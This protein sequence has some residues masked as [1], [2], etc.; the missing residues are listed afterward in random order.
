LFLSILL[1]YRSY[2]TKIQL[3]VLLRV[4]FLY[5][6]LHPTVTALTLEGAAPTS[7]GVARRRPPLP[8]RA[9]AT[10]TTT[11]IM[12]QAPPM[13]KSNMHK[14]NYGRLFFSSASCGKND[15]EILVWRV[16]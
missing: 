16:K 13:I 4:H 14:A 3:C 11:T 15:W 10:T 8:L 2:I 7:A 5:A 6:Q 1:K 9:T 12:W